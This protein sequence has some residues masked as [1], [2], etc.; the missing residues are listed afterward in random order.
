[1]NWDR[2]QNSVL[3]QFRVHHLGGVALRRLFALRLASMLIL[4]T[5]LA[6]GAADWMDRVPPK[7]HARP[8]PLASNSEAVH[9]GALLYK[10]HCAQCHQADAAGDGKKK[11]S[12]KT[13]R[14]RTATDGDLEW[15]LRQGDLAHG[16]PSWSNLPQGQRWQIIA[17]LRSL[18]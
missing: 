5:S 8:N 6:F 14:I 15:Y 1:M 16:M 17:W 9:A 11:P 2:G 12:L 7:D 10:Q 18:Q 4:F 13:D 3:S